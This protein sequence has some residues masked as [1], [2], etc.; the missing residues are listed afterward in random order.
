MK[1]EEIYYHENNPSRSEN[2]LSKH[3]ESESAFV[4]SNTNE[5]MATPSQFPSSDGYIKI[6]ASSLLVISYV[7]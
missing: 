7:K 2:R 4:D 3:E 6:M 5:N 1:L